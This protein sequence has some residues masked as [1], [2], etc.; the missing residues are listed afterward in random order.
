M[1]ADWAPN[2]TA[3]ERAKEFR[4]SLAEETEDFKLWTTA[5]GYQFAG[6]RGW[7]AAFM[8]HLRSQH[9]RKLERG[10]GRQSEE[11]WKAQKAEAHRGR[12]Y[13]IF[14]ASDELS[15]EQEAE[16]QIWV[17]QKE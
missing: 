11:T 14:K 5:K 1:P 3:R 13:P 2:A 9:K 16:A 17:D 8:N 4:L 6:P 10:T 7:D 15:P 12:N